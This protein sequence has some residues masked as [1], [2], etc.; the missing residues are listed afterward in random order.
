M[1][2]NKNL[3]ITDKLFFE[4]N[5][6]SK[7]KISKK[8][9]ESLLNFDDGELYLEDSHNETFLYDD[10][11]MKN[12]SFNNSQGFG[13]RSIA[14]EIRGYAHSS[15]ISE[16]NIFKAIETI[17]SISKDSYNNNLSLNNMH[18]NEPLYTS[19]NPLQNTEFSRKIKTL[20]NIDKFARN[21]DSRVIQVSTSLSGSYKAIQILQ[22]ENLSTAD[23]RPLVRLNIQI[24]VQHKGRRE[25]GSSGYGGRTLYDHWLKEENWKKQVIEALRIATLNLESKPAPAGEIPV[26]LGSGWPGVMLHEAVGHGLEGDFNR[27]GSSVFSNKIGEKVASEGVTVIDDGTMKNRRGSITID[28]EGTPSGKNILIENGILKNYMQDK[29]NAR[30]MN[31]KPTGNGRRESYSHYPMPRMT[32]TFMANGK[33]EPEEIISSVKKGVYA[34]NFSGGQVDITSGKFVF[35]ASEAYFIEDGKIIY[36]LKGATLIGNGP[37]AMNKIKMIGNDLKLDEGIGTCGKNGQGVPVGVGQPSLLM[38]GITIGGTET[39]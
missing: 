39:S 24:V 7:D 29:Q 4:N 37:D 25:S 11:R 28:D 31:M 26:V 21:L 27:K 22:S 2:E 10:G 18:R 16:K 36:P 19:Q 33:Y 14:G 5:D 17:K 8:L 20:E 23:L 34:V 30:L 13:V 9:N 6:I 35:S 15:E 32:N 38:E 3:E 1:K 12:V